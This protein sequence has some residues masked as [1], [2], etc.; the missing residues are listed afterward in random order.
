ME[1]VVYSVEHANMQEGVDAPA[2]EGEDEVTAVSVAGAVDAA[3]QSLILSVQ[4][5][6]ALSGMAFS[7]GAVR[8]LP[9]LTSEAFD[10]K[11]AVSAL[12]HVGFEATYGEMKLKKLTGHALPCHWLSQKRGGRGGSS[13]ALGDAG[14][15]HLRRFSAEDTFGEEHLPLKNSMPT[16]ALF[17]SGAPGA[18]CGQG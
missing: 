17:C 7:P 16:G 9:E 14:I 4:H 15:V 13:I 6:L 18:C 11:S 1:P 10:P 2:F 5:I 3:E 12:R 8:D